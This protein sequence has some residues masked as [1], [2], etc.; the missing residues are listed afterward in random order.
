MSKTTLSQDE[1]LELIDAPSQVTAG[2]K[3]KE[4]K[5]K[6]K[7]DDRQPGSIS[8]ELR[9]RM[10]DPLADIFSEKGQ[11]LYDKGVSA[12]QNE[13]KK[14]FDEGIA[15]LSA[16]IKKKLGEYGYDESVDHFRPWMS[17]IIRD[18]KDTGMGEVTGALEDML[19]QMSTDYAE[20]DVGE[21][22]AALLGTEAPEVPEGDVEEIVKE[23]EVEEPAPPAPAPG[24]EGGEA[25]APPP[26]PGGEAGGADLGALLGG[27]T[28]AAGASAEDG[29]KR[30]FQPTPEMK[31]VFA[32]SRR[33]HR[34]LEAADQHL[35]TLQK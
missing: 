35:K 10:S 4:D 13:L 16:V 23:E 6:G 14:I 1:L 12:I 24:G 7:K 11:E 18:V 26:A 30:K 32:A 33:R 17:D 31:E 34:L 25:P 20:D 29:R 2:R 19:S 27:E 8:K 5:E 15:D 22:E 9:R 3:K 21:G 28:P